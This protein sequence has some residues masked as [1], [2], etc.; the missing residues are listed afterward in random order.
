MTT[1]P[2]V[3]RSRRAPAATAADVPLVALLGRAHD[4]FVRDFDQ[5]MADTEFCALSMGASRNV[6]RNLADGPLRASQLVERCGVSKQALS[7]QIARLQG[8][9][10]LEVTP[11]PLDHRARVLRLTAR[12]RRAQDLVVRTLTEIEA[13]WCERLGLTEV[14]TLRATLHAVLE[15]HDIEPH[16][17]AVD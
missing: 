13:Q 2:S 5:R 15:E 8:A 1:T 7:Q 4:A 11:D 12:G 3:A 6:L 16:C 17:T 10:Y 14:E 9:G